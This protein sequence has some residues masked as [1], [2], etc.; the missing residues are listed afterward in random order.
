MG[1]SGEGAKDGRWLDKKFGLIR[2][3][4]GKNLFDADLF[5]V[6]TWG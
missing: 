2:L 1:E 5:G 6:G 4:R 3:I